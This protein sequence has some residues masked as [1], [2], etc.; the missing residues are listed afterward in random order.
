MHFLCWDKSCARTHAQRRRTHKLSWMKDLTTRSPRLTPDGSFSAST[1]YA[2]ASCANRRCNSHH[3]EYFFALTAIYLWDIERPATLVSRDRVSR[4][5]L[6]QQQIAH[7]TIEER[8]LS[9]R[10]IIPQQHTPFHIVI[11]V[12]RVRG[13]T[14]DNWL[15]G[16]DRGHGITLTPA[17]MELMPKTP[18]MDFLGWCTKIQSQA[19]SKPQES[20]LSPTC[21][22]GSLYSIVLTFLH[23]VMTFIHSLSL[24]SNT[25]HLTLTVRLH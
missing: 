8:R 18:D 21:A 1:G 20:T 6:S 24:S 4:G 23:W 12:V 13:R 11:R 25:Q 16:K 5:G 15:T 9:Q 19:R 3:I 7:E 2:A 17:R 14:D 22:L 10:E